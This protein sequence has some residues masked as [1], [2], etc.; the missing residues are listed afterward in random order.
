MKKHWRDS[1]PLIRDVRFEGDNL[2]VE[3]EAP[4]ECKAVA[5]EEKAGEIIDFIRPGVSGFIPIQPTVEDLKRPNLSLVNKT[6]EITIGP[7]DTSANE[8]AERCTGATQSFSARLRRIF[9]K[10]ALRCR[11][12]MFAH[13]RHVAS[14]LLTLPDPSRIHRLD[15]GLQRNMG[16]EKARD[17]TS[18]VDWEGWGDKGDKS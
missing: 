18:I 10:Q 4:E 11:L 17:N 1:V 12:R 6:S 9:E 7:A 3:L 15:L 2:V 14:S 13:L 5:S 8:I 16:T